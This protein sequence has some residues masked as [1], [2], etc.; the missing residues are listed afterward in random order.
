M[1]RR[2]TFY[3]ILCFFASFSLSSQDLHFSNYT[4][5]PLF[6]NPAN[7]GAFEGTYRVGAS[8]RSQF[9]TFF[10]NPY[11]STLAYADSPMSFVMDNKGWIGGGLMV[12]QDQVGDLGIGHT[13]VM[14]N[15]AL[16]Y[17]LDEDYESVVSLGAQFGRIAYRSKIKLF[18]PGSGLGR[19]DFDFNYVDED[20]FAPG[21]FDASLG[22]KFQQK[23]SKTSCYILGAAYQ[24]LTSPKYS[25]NNSSITN[26]I[27]SRINVHGQFITSPSD[28]VTWKPTVYFS[29]TEGFTNIIG[30]ILGE[31][32]VNKKS[33][34]KLNYGLGYRTGDAAIITLGFIYE[35]W[36]FAF[37][38]D[39]T[40]SSASQYDNY[41]GGIELGVYKTF[42]VNKKPKKIK[43][44][45]QEFLPN[46]K[47]LCPRL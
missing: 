22:L 46:L 1:R 10:D 41:T 34:T 40:L 43:K 8:Y 32:K 11:V 15:V 26:I 29:R 24:H 6:F 47:M 45:D 3:S 4:Y 31:Y 33:E 17:A 7:T 37:N 36:N 35:G 13:A 5:S 30:Q 12:Y 19:D 18:D 42:V 23:M 21:Y 14:G 25:F 38:Y 9:F 20:N 39:L 28:R 44:G 2:T 16:H 27:G